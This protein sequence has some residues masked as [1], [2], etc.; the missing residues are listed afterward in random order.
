MKRNSNAHKILKYLAI[1]GGIVL[2]SLISPSGS[3]VILQS[4]FKNYLRKKRFERERFLRDLK[5]LQER[6]LI[7]YRE[8]SNGKVEI[9]LTK[10]GKEK[11][12]KYDIDEIKLDTTK[13]WDRKWRLVMFD[14]PHYKKKARDAFREKLRELGFYAIQKSVYIVPHPCEDEIDFI[15]SVFDIRHFVL[16]LYVNKFEGGEKFKYHFNLV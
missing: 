2:L 10:L 13:K 14:I 4:I 7:D 5:N 16:I 11:I 1:G 15:C 12:L 6:E 9:K 8:F 3:S